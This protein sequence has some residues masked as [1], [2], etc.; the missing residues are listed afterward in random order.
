MQR[1][2]SIVAGLALILVGALF[3]AGN[4][5]LPMFGVQIIW[6]PVW[7]LWP[8]FVLALGGLMAAPA[9]F[10]ADRRG[11]GA[12][13]I[14]ATPV[15]T[16]GA[17]LL[18]AS[19]T[20]QW[21]VWEIAWPLV[22]LAVAV[23]FTLAAIFTRIVWFGVPAILIGLNAL[24]LAFCSWTGL[25]S[26]WSVLWTIEPFAVGLALL[27]V[28]LKTRVWPV[29]IVGVLFCEF[30]WMALFTS[31]GVRFLGGWVLRLVAPGMIILAGGILL[32]WSFFSRPIQR[33]NQ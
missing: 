11:L 33:L 5:V 1:L 7:R 28:S 13:F 26:S 19:V 6:F 3:L 27:L 22:V 16:V 23:G 15:L 29:A 9:L 20:G 32:V 18:F 12:L 21:G 2:F 24:V 8:L 25:W 4:L 17:I 10:S 30:A 14:P 31:V